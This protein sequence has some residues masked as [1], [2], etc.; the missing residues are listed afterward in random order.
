MVNAKCKPGCTCRRHRPH[1]P[2][3]T[4]P[5]ALPTS[6]TNDEAVA[7]AP[8]G[9]ER[10]VEID[11]APSPAEVDEVFA[12]VIDVQDHA[13]DI[14]AQRVAAADPTS[15]DALKARLAVVI[16]RHW[17]DLSDHGGDPTD[18]MLDDLL[19][20][21]EQVDHRDAFFRNAAPSS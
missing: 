8:D 19:A 13:L 21:V 17:R 4:S 20:A 16:R 1:V 15:R 14:L 12:R 6:R 5:V 10:A 11:G 9:I 7:L 18:R 3:A 2:K